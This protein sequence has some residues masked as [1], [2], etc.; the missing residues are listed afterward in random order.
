MRVLVVDDSATM[1]NIIKRGLGTLNVTTV[2]E[3]SDGVQGL[4]Q[5]KGGT[6][7]LVLSDWNMPNMDGLQFLKEVR[8]LDSKIPFIMVTTEGERARV[9]SAIEAG[10]SDYLVKPFTVDALKAKLEKWVSVP[11]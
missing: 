6:F 4:N 7:D 8:Q 9:V 11:T 5:F 3:A 10:V 2:S 1:R